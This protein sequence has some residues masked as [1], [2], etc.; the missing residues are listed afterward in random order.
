MF[1]FGFA[2]LVAD[3]SVNTGTVLCGSRFQT[4]QATTPKKKQS[5]S[6]SR[7]PTLSF[8]NLI[9]ALA[10]SA[11]LIDARFHTS[12]Y[13]SILALIQSLSPLQSSILNGHSDSINGNQASSCSS[14]RFPSELKRDWSGGIQPTC[15]LPPAA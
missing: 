14:S 3:L 1:D 4:G 2:L 7:I 10:Y 9:Q 12:N 6:S 11:P 5:T 13:Q 8:S 15:N